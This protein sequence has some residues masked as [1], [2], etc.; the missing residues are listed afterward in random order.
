MLRVKRWIPAT[1]AVIVAGGAA[2]AAAAWL[3]RPVELRVGRPQRGE[4]VEVVYATGFVE[5]KHPVSL[6]SRLTAPVLTVDADEGDRVRRADPLITLDGAEQRSLLAQ[7]RAQRR[8]ADQRE[9]RVVASFRQGWMTRAAR[10]EAV[11]AAA[12][13]RAGESAAAARVAQ[14]ILRAPV[15]GIVL[16]REVEPGDLAAPGVVLM[17]IGDPRQMRITATVDERDVLGV[18]PGQDVLLSSDGLGGRVLRAV[19]SSITPGGDPNQRAFRVRLRLVD[20]VE[21]PFGLTL[22]AN[23]VTRRVRN[24]L[25]VPASAYGE[26]FVWVV[27]DE[28]RSRKRRVKAGVTGAEAVQIVT[29]LGHADRVILS[30]PTDLKDGTRVRA[31]R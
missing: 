17:Q 16:K 18:R 7:A 21:L 2:A 6:S 15:S 13:A 30:P 29:G 27:D 31:A 14:T 12:A 25:L 3:E 20:A 26:G 8:G 19:V 9:Q 4:A 10:D 22:E 11:A 28:G 5:P 24:A 1:I 23:I